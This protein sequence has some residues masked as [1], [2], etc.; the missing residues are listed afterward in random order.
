MFRMISKYWQGIVSNFL[1]T[2]STRFRVSRTSLVSV[3]LYI[4]VDSNVFSIVYD[5]Y[6][7]VYK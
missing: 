7:K 5:V 3:E 2:L 1:E 4:W 6:R